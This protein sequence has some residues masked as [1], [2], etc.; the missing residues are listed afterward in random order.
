MYLRGR[1]KDLIVL[2]NGQNVYPEDIERLL[3]AN[4]AITEGVIVG[5]P[6]EKNGGETVHA[7]LLTEGSTGLIK[8]VVEEVN[9]KLADHQ[10]ISGYTIWPE[11]DLP[12]TH[13]MK[14]RKGLVVDFLKAASSQSSETSA[15]SPKSASPAVVDPLTRIIS[16]VA[17][18]RVQEVEPGKTLADDL[19]L[20]S[21]K[22]VELLSLVEQELSTYI[23]EAL[24]SPTTT[25]AE[26]KELVERHPRSAS[27]GL[28]FYSWSLTR[29][30]TTL[31][32]TLLR[33][34]V[35][36]WLSTL[37]RSTVTGQDNL[38]RVKGPVLRHK[39]QRRC[40]GQPSGP[41]GASKPV[42]MADVLCG[43]GG[44]NLRKA[45]VGYPGFLGGQRLPT[46]QG[47]GDSSQPGAP[48]WSP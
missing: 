23:D 24:L 36:P 32:A 17:Q 5:L 30:C 11:E 40:L 4:Q 15:S 45:L 46:V 8:E 1:K 10:R 2:A 27:P 44:D 28:R 37:Y 38:K 6:D 20:D 25:V 43:G 18:V 19:G 7:V 21:L 34:I 31:R 12:R 35:F 26:L 33:T 42:A 22:R 39:P 14:V 13:T 3:N 47:H 29:W 9:A 41:Q 16:Q 48:G